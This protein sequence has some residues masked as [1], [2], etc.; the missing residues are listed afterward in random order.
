MGAPR[1]T[2]AK[3]TRAV[4]AAEACGLVVAGLKIGP[5]GSI[6]IRCQVDKTAERPQRREPKEW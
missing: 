3:I 1:L 4:K 5:D 6:E 2:Q